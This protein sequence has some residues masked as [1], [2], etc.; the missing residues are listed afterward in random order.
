MLVYTGLCTTATNDIPCVRDSVWR[1]LGWT[2]NFNTNG[3]GAASLADYGGCSGGLERQERRHAALGAAYS[4]GGIGWIDSEDQP[5]RVGST[6]PTSASQHGSGSYD[7]GM[8]R[9]THWGYTSS[10]GTTRKG[11][12]DGCRHEE[13]DSGSGTRRQRAAQLPG[14]GFMRAVSRGEAK[15][16]ARAPLE[17]GRA[18]GRVAGVDN[19][20]SAARHARRLRRRIGPPGWDELGWLVAAVGGGGSNTAREQVHRLAQ[21]RGG[22]GGIWSAG[23]IGGTRAGWRNPGP[24]ARG[25]VLANGVLDVRGYARR[26]AGGNRNSPEWYS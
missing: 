24:L 11:C 4:S 12:R 6:G 13:D 9:P 17:V 20:N 14:I 1:H 19:D 5:G 7:E 25:G 2:A 10:T 21:A 18:V 16:T 15:A 23:W 3:F 26:G 22:A 8:G